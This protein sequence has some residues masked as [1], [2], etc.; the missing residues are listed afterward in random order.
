MSPL[1]Q[2][3]E[4]LFNAVGTLVSGLLTSLIGVLINS[5]LTPLIDAL[6]AAIGISSM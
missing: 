3:G 5:V 2:I 4:L 1:Q 6:F